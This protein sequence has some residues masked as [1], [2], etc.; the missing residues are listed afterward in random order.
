MSDGLYDADDDKCVADLVLKIDTFISEV[1]KSCSSGQEASTIDDT[2]RLLDNESTCVI[3]ILENNMTLDNTSQYETERVQS[4]DGDNGT[5]EKQQLAQIGEMNRFVIRHNYHDYSLP[6]SIEKFF[7]SQEIKKLE[8]RRTEIVTSLSK[9]IC[10]NTSEFPTK[11]RVPFPL[12]LHQLLEDATKNNKVDVVAWQDH[13]RSFRVIDRKRFVS[14]VLPIYF[15]QTRYS[16]FLR[17]LSLY[18]FLRM[19]KKGKDCGSYYHER[20]LRGNRLLACVIDRTAV[21][22]T[23]VPYLPSPDTEPNFDKMPPVG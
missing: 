17:Q 12:A 7:S 23:G 10:R 18:G 20:F 14:E 19:T 1:R 2:C 13:G 22:G 6:G 11:K 9:T 4:I 8:K 3:N 15:N 21:K 16:S 5:I